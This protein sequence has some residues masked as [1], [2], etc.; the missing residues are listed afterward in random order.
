MKKCIAIIQARMGSRRLPGKVMLKLDTENSLE[1]LIRTCRQVSQLDD[2]IIATSN[3]LDDD[4]IQDFCENI[5]VPFY[6]GSEEDVLSRFLDIAHV[7][8]P[9]LIV[10][11]TGDCPFAKSDLIERA[12]DLLLHKQLDYVCLSPRF[13]EGVDVEVFTNKCLEKIN[14]LSL[15]QRLREHV[16]LA[17]HQNIEAFSIG[18]IENP[19]D[20]SDIRITLDEPE[21]FKVIKGLLETI[22]EDMDRLPYEQLIHKIRK[23]PQITKANMHII[24]NAAI[25]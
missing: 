18:K 22:G 14:V 11:L 9:N 23:V 25:T 20:D 7:Q 19:L 17:L 8:K 4:R 13:A 16:T 12:I 10:R 3:S 6:R 2:V 1:K 5:E 15:N 24:R 21:D